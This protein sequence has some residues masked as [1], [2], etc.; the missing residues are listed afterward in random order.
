[1]SARFVNIDRETPMMFPATVQELLPE[2]HLARF[3]VDAASEIDTG[4]FKVNNSGSGDE[5]YPP[6]MMLA[7]VIY[8]YATGIFSSRKIQEASYYNVPVMYI[9]GMRA[10]PDFSRICAFRRENKAAISGAFGK[11]LMMAQEA[12]FLKDRVDISVDGTKIQANASKH[13]AVSYKRAVE[14]IAEIEGEVKELMEKAENADS[15]PLAAGL[16]IEKEISMREDRKTVLLAAKAEMERRYAEAEKEGEREKE[17]GKGGSGGKKPLEEYQYNFTD[18]ESR[19][20]KKGNSFEQCYN[21]QAAVDVESM[22]IVGGYVTAHCND[23]KELAPVV[24]DAADNVEKINTVSVD[25]GFYSEAA[26]KEVE[27]VDD[28]GN[29]QG[30][31][32][33]CAVEKTGH[34]LSVKDLEANSGPAGRIPKNA[35]AKERMARKLKTKRGRAVYKRRKETVEPV[36][37]VIKS[38]MGFR[39]FLLRGLEKVG[40]EWE[41]VKTAYNFKKLHRL[42]YGITMPICPVMG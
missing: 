11:V 34:H 5:Q 24:Q 21:G 29:R 40:I 23:K 13:K 15:R 31:E 30:P 14:R 4:E 1:M 37:G 7:L 28:A 10:H 9:C 12:G 3:I 8:C 38:V 19:I 26:I 42:M 2:N 17:S 18:P 16:T 35:G 41:L 20:M 36:F 25:T 32:V 6:E 33:F 39:Q 22:L 27:Q